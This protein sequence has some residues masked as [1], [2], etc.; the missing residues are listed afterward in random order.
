M[1]TLPKCTLQSIHLIRQRS[2]TNTWN[3]VKSDPPPP[4]APMATTS[5]PAFN[6]SMPN[7]QHTV[8]TKL[9]PLQPFIEFHDF[10]ELLCLQGIATVRFAFRLHPLYA[11]FFLLVSENA[12]ALRSSSVG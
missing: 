5:S 7:V 3:F 1:G 11:A 6:F 10:P 4:I 8:A 12:S 2:V 9:S